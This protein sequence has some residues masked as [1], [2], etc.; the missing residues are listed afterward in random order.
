M[1]MRVKLRA[2]LSKHINYHLE[3]YDPSVTRDF[4]DL[5]L[6][7]INRGDETHGSFLGEE[8]DLNLRVTLLDLFTAGV[9]TTATTLNWA[10]LFLSQCPQVQAKLQ[11]EIDRV[12]GD[13][14]PSR[15]DKVRMVYME[16]FLNEVHRM[17]SILPM[18]VYHRTMKDT[19]FAGYFLPRGS[20]LFLNLHDAHHD[21]AV[22]GDPEVFRPERFLNKDETQIVKNEALVAF[23]AGKRQCLGELLARDSLFIFVTGLV[24]NFSFK[25]EG[26]LNMEGTPTFVSSPQQFEV[27][28][29]ERKF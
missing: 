27:I 15:D 24:R 22:W 14:N 1:D 18:S 26:K 17:S 4:I 7:E 10:S 13:R 25:S 9:E 12:V 16:A 23:G 8:G 3:T 5:Y 21:P 20:V 6:H 11:E 19:E 2:M 29:E 28:L